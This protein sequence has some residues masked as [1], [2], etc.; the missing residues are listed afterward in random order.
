MLTQLLEP[1]V[2]SQEMLEVEL[3]Q[4]LQEQIDTLLER[5][6]KLENDLYEG[7]DRDCRLAK[8]RKMILEEEL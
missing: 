5:C 8:M 4:G 1:V 3:R 2:R 6:L 7:L